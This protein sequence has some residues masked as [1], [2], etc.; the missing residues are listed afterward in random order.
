MNFLFKAFGWVPR[1]F[2]WGSR[3]TEAAED[4]R[5]GVQAARDISEE[6]AAA[7]ALAKKWGVKPK[8][9]PIEP[10]I[11]P[12]VDL[13][14]EATPLPR[15]A[16]SAPNRG[17][18][19]TSVLGGSIGTIVGTSGAYALFKDL[20][21]TIL[22]NYTSDLED[23][24]PVSGAFRDVTKAIRAQQTIGQQGEAEQKAAQANAL[25]DHAPSYLQIQQ[26]LQRRQSHPQP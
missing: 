6:D 24:L 26:E 21:Q 15:Q 14:Q 13:G 19:K 3:A 20:P 25:T 7:A 22:A 23:W 17:V 9:K 8:A 11:E 10:K 12:K 18:L 5:S 4:L 1:L 2:K 16:P